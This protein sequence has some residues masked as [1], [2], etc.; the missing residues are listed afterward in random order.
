MNLEQQ[1]EKSRTFLMTLDKPDAKFLGDI[2]R[3][4]L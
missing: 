1:K 2:A 4:R 3:G